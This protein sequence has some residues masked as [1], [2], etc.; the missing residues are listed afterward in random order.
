MRMVEKFG[1]GILE[2][3]AEKVQIWRAILIVEEE[4]RRQDKG[5]DPPANTKEAA[6]DALS[7]P[8]PS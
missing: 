3:P 1:L 7:R 2:M 8:S 4:K 5:E 6:M